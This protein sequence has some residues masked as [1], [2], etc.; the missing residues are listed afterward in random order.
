MSRWID[1]DHGARSPGQPEGGSAPAMQ[2]GAAF[3]AP[4]FLAL[5]E[6]GRVLQK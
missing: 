3:A 6:Y 1:P 5:L 4:F 2:K